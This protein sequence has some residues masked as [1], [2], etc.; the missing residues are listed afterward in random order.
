MGGAERKR[1]LDAGLLH[2]ICRLVPLSGHAARVVRCPLS[3]AKRTWLKDGVISA[4]DPFRT[5]AHC[6]CLD[7]DSSERSGTSHEGGNSEERQNPCVHTDIEEDAEIQ[8]EKSFY[9]TLNRQ[10][11]CEFQAAKRPAVRPGSFFPCRW[12][13]LLPM[14]SS[15]LLGCEG[16]IAQVSSLLR[17]AF[18]PEDEKL[19]SILSGMGAVCLAGLEM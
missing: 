18:G 4:Y 16:E 5:S 6:L 15:C 1:E 19:A 14:G 9:E 3:G 13:L 8:P 12:I 10:S 11:I 7:S 2:C 17:G